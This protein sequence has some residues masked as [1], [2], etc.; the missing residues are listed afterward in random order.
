MIAL[1]GSISYMHVSNNISF[2]LTSYLGSLLYTSRLRGIPLQMVD[3][4]LWLCLPEA[5]A[6]VDKQPLLL[7]A[8]Q[9]SPKKS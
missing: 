7:Q 5:R 6:G 1:L 8:E 3:G 2:N 9:R 4:A